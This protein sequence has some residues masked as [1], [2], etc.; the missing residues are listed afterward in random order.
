MYAPDE[1]QW[2]LLAQADV[3]DELTRRPVTAVTTAR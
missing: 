2:E 3:L 1:R